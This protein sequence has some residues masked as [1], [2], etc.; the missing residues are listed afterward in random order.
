[1][2]NNYYTEYKKL[3]TFYRVKVYNLL[4]K[5]LDTKYEITGCNKKILKYYLTLI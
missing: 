3:K 2:D 4:K 1:M 5:L